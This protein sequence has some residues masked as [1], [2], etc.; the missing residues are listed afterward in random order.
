MG[1]FQIF[2][3]GWFFRR[4]DVRRIVQALAAAAGARA[5]PALVADRGACVF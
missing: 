4:S 2:S 1:W 5:F 3:L